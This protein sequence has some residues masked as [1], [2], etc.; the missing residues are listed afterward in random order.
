MLDAVRPGARGGQV[1]IWG[2]PATV[3][4]QKLVL[5]D[6]RRRSPGVRAAAGLL[7]V[8]SCL[9]GAVTDNKGRG[10]RRA[11]DVPPLHGTDEDLGAHERQGG[12]VLAHGG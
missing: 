9:A 10:D 11:V 1:S 7:R 8:S 6:R 5:G 12:E 3:D 2:A 4:M